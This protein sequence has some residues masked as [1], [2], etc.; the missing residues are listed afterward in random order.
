MERFQRNP[1]ARPSHIAA[2]C[3]LLM[4]LVVLQ[5]GKVPF[6]LAYATVAIWTFVAGTL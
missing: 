2:S 3:M 5:L 6:V 4:K 1:G